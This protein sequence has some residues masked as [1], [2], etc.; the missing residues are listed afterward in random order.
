MKVDGDMAL[1]IYFI[2]FH[3]SLLIY[4]E[5]ANVVNLESIRFCVTAEQLDLIITNQLKLFKG[6][7]LTK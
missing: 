6:I 5:Y 3:F 2:F 1:I 7:I 4:F